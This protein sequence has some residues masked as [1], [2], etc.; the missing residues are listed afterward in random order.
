MGKQT[1]TTSDNQIKKTSLESFKESKSTYKVKCK[2]EAPLII[3]RD[4]K[5]SHSSY[6]LDDVFLYFAP[7]S[8]LSFEICD[9]GDYSFTI[10]EA[11]KFIE[12]LKLALEYVNGLDI[13]KLKISN[14][15]EANNDSSNQPEEVILRLPLTKAKQKRLKLISKIPYGIHEILVDVIQSP[16]VSS[17]MIRLVFPDYK[18]VTYGF[19]ITTAQKFIDELINTIKYVQKNPPL[20]ISDM[21]SG[22]V[23]ATKK[24]Q[25]SR[26]FEVGTDGIIYNNEE[27]NLV[28]INIY[29]VERG[30]LLATRWFDDDEVSI[31]AGILAKSANEINNLQTDSI[32]NLIQQNQK[33][34]IQFLVTSR[35]IISVDFLPNEIKSP[36][37]KLLFKYNGVTRVG[38]DDI[39]WLT[40]DN[41]RELSRLMFDALKN[42]A[43]HPVHVYKSSQPTKITIAYLRA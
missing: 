16:D 31:L 36:G 35:L 6:P 20:I 17:L 2:I 33:K 37:I 5:G 7:S 21:I 1:Q 23:I 30:Y 11:E 28:F 29:D 9:E 32:N 39:F 26:Y 18:A 34:S 43:N 24:S 38:D 22:K 10:Q 40:E 4:T 42:K 19:T 15:E 41:A 13:A 3:Y 27:P 25:E 8:E 12:P 14:L